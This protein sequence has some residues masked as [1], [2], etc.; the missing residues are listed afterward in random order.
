MSYGIIFWYSLKMMPPRPP[1]QMNPA[2]VAYLGYGVV[3]AFF[4]G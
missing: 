4:D 3:V 1:H 2:R